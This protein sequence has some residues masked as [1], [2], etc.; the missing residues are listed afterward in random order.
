[1]IGLGHDIL[2]G[3][4]CS[5]LM[6]KILVDLTDA[7]VACKI[8]FCFNWWH[9]IVLKSTLHLCASKQEY[10]FEPNLKIFNE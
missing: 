10:R 4:E 7:F 9:L 5:I 3:L 8:Q 2:N 6:T 1:M